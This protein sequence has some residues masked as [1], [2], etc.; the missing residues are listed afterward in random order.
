MEPHDDI[1]DLEFMENEQFLKMLELEE[2]KIYL[3]SVN[4]NNREV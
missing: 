4:K 2:L 3:D 1:E